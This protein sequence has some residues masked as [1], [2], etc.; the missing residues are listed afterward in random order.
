MK[1]LNP[2]GMQSTIMFVF[3]VIT[4]SL[5]LVLGIVMYIRFSIS[6]RQETIQSTKKLMEQTG[7]SLENYLVSMRQISDAV[8]YNVIKEN[9]F[10]SKDNSIQQG[11]NL[12]YEA[13]KTS[14]RSIAIYNGNGK[15]TLMSQSRTG[16][17]RQRNRWRICIFQRRIS[18]IF[19]MMTAD[20]ITG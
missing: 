13:N 14:L 15:R 3:T 6:S 20:A 16:I 10:S 18:K 19:L 1:K 5:M 11:M 17:C 12:L 4:I 9:D 8:Y 7:E 2:R